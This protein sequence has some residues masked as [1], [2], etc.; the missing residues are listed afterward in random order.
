L[1][2][3]SQIRKDAD[4]FFPYLFTY[5]EDSRIIDSETGLPSVV[6]FCEHF[7]EAIGRDADHIM[8]QALTK[9]LDLSLSIA[10][11]DQSKGIESGGHGVLGSTSVDMIS[12]T[13]Q[14]FDLGE[15]LLLLR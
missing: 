8:V 13:G 11:L 7:V 9:A 10:Y 1:I 15:A 14:Q 12:F 4:E 6:R 5:D 3:S 2:T